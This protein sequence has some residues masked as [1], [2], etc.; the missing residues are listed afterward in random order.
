MK[1]AD[2]SRPPRAFPSLEQVTKP[3]VDTESAAYY[4]NRRP[5]TLRAWAMRD[6]KGPLRCIRVNGRLAW[7]V[8]GIKKLLKI[9]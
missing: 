5:Q 7:P 2:P 9:A 3:T 4:L 6:G 1:S 8:D